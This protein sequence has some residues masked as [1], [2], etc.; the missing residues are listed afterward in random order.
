MPGGMQQFSAGTDCDGSVT[1]SYTWTVSG[2]AGGTIDRSGLY[3]AG[4]TDGTDTAY[5]NATDTATA[6]V[7]FKSITIAPSTMLRSRWIM[8]PAFVFINGK[9]TNFALSKTDLYYESVFSVFPLSVLVL[10]PTTIW[11]LILV[12]PAWLVGYEQTETVTV[13]VTTG[14]ESVSGTFA[15][16]LLPFILDEQKNIK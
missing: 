12:N 6:V 7:T 11:Q 9:G 13:T 4:S 10:G 3:T 14:T 8:L 15:I 5:L 2:S 16:E 1:E